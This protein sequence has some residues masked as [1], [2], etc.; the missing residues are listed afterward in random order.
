MAYFLGKEI[1]GNMDDLLPDIGQN[2][3]DCL[4]KCKEQMALDPGFDYNGCVEGCGGMRIQPGQPAPQITTP[5]TITAPAVTETPIEPVA[6]TDTNFLDDLIA[7]MF[8]KG[9]ETVRGLG[10]RTRESV[11]DML[12][13]EGLMGTGA[14]RDVAQD[15][16]W[17]TE[18]GISDLMR[19]VEQFKYQQEQETMNQMLQYLF[20]MMGAWR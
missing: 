4:Q 8:G 19:G 13:R 16:A 1:A 2:K 9:F 3:G 5:G 15:I 12:A 14:A 10:G 17:Q 20:S 18:T 11:F 6:Q 7:G